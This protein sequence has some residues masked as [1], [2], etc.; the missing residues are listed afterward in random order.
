MLKNVDDSLIYYVFTTHPGGGWY[1]DA[2]T[3]DRSWVYKDTRI[4]YLSF[5]GVTCKVE[6][7][8]EDGE[9]LDTDVI[10]PDHE[11][12]ERYRVAQTR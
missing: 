8:S 1:L 6:A 11:R 2:I 4:D 9:L 10:R 12:A 5:L 3:R 7:R